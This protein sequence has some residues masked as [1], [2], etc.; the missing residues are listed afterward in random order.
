MRLQHIEYVTVIFARRF[1]TRKC[2]PLIRNPSR[3]YGGRRAQTM[4]KSILEQ[5]EQY[6]RLFR[7]RSSCDVDENPC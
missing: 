2:S 5:A 6:T 1:S 7:E 4:Q 3:S